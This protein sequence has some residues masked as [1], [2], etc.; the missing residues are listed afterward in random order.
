MS[1]DSVYLNQF[2]RDNVKEQHLSRPIALAYQYSL[3]IYK[4]AGNN[5]SRDP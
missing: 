1:A 5:D 4:S 3:F 2:L